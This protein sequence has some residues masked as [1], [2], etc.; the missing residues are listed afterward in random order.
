M[1]K[2]NKED[3]PCG[4]DECGKPEWQDE[5][6]QVWQRWIWL[7]DHDRTYSFG[8]PLPLTTKAV[9]D[10]CELYDLTIDDFESIFKI[11]K[12]MF[13]MIQEKNKG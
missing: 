12:I 5:N 8:G 7:N 4:T 2:L 3:P 6:L 9:L 13:P 1:Y 10:L 11:E